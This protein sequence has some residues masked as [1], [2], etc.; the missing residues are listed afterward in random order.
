[1]I[2][3]SEQKA[4]FDSLTGDLTINTDPDGESGEDIVIPVEVNWGGEPKEL[5]LPSIT[6]KFI[7]YGTKLERTL[8]DLWKDTTEGYFIGFVGGY[9]LLVKIR[10][11]DHEDSDGNFIEKTDIAEALYQRVFLQALHNWDALI[12][13]GS[14][15]EDG[16]DQATDV[17]EIIGLEEIKEL[18]FNIRLKKLTGGVP[19]ETGPVKFSTAPTILSVD[20][21]VE[22]A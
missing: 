12:T 8:G 6:I 2:T 11:K 21:T 18:Q 13:D 14:V 9:T 7:V 19:I 15:Q 4:L 22:F 20:S 3:R 16:I 17:S 1:M 5:E 10:T